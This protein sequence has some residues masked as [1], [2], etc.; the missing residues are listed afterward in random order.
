MRFCGE[1][2]IRTPGPVTVNGFQDHRIRPLCHFTSRNDCAFADA[3]IES[4]LSSKKKK[5]T[6][7]NKNFVLIPQVFIILLQTNLYRQC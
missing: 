3:N 4:F 7:Y 2:G 5:E 1:R 6:F